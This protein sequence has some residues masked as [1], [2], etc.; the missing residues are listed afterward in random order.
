MSPYPTSNLYARGCYHG[1]N[2]RPLDFRSNAY[3]DRALAA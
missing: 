3:S 1:V 2:E